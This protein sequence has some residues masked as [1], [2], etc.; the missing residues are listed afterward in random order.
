[1]S[2]ATNIF[3]Q[4]AEYSQKIKELEQLKEDLKPQ[5]L[6]AIDDAPDH[7]MNTE[8]GYFSAMERK[9][10]TYSDSITSL[11]AEIK[12]V[13]KQEEADGTAT[14]KSITRYPV[15]SERKE[16]AAD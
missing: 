11:E 13:K 2:A 1:M 16:N 6:E 3:K 10:Y 7:F 12:K 9:S 14:I 5:I 8:F 15:F 4:Y